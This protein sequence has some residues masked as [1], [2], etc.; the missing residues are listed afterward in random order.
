MIQIN[1]V[2]CPPPFAGLFLRG[3]GQF[4]K[5]ENGLFDGTHGVS[6]SAQGAQQC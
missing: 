2:I 5:L 4:G 1:V 3:V 6:F